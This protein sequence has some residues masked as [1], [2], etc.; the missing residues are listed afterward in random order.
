[1]DTQ[2]E[3]IIKSGFRTFFKALLGV[4][5]TLLGIGAIFLLFSLFIPSSH[6]VVDRTSVHIAP[7]AD[8]ER[9]LLPRAPIVL[10]MNIQGVIGDRHMGAS[11][12]QRQLDDSQGGAIA[13]GRVKAILL[14]INSPGGSATDSDDIYRALLAYKE[15]HKVPVYA[16]VNGM[17]ASGAMYSAC[18][19][20]KIFATPTSVIGSVGVLLGPNFNV[21]ELMEKV[22][23]SELTITKGTDKAPLSPFRPWQKGE[24]QPL[25]EITDYLY[26]RFV[27][28]VAKSRP[29]LTLDL[30]KNTY[31]AK[32]FAAP[33]ALEHG[34][35]D[36]DMASYQ[37]AVSELVKAA[38]IEGPYQ[39]LSLKPETPILQEFIKN[40]SPLITEKLTHKFFD[41]GL[42]IQDA[43]L[44]IY[45]H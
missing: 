14:D 43:F 32:V 36:N 20:D 21:S 5:G 18:A 37:L 19:A 44:Y 22:G 39:V 24:E 8:G 23:V 11:D 9:Q 45:S 27:N 7:N 4:F 13:P 38:D 26:D 42:P 33:V 16:F 41:E 25:E 28:I 31:G 3:S 35:I 29:K 15:E 34:Y 6:I 1:M 40:Q 12:I 30:L 17:C 2:N 10:K